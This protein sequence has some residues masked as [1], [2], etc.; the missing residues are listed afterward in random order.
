MKLNKSQGF[1]AFTIP[2][3][4]TASLMKESKLVG[5]AIEK[6]KEDARQEYV[7]DGGELEV[8]F[9]YEGCTYTATGDKCLMGQ[10]SRPSS[11]IT[12][13]DVEYLVYREI[14]ILA[15]M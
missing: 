4:A 8:A 14:D 15:V 12:V 1:I 10:G 5:P 13:E 9:T 2:V 3:E 6:A 11:V 7:G